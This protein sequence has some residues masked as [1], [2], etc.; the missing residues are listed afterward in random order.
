MNTCD[1]KEYLARREIPQL[2]ESL[3][4]GLVCYKPD[5]PI[6]YLEGC[7]QKVKE[8]GGSEKVKWDTFVSQEKRTLPP[9]NG[10]QSRR[11]FFRNVMPDNPNFPYRRYDRLPP[12]HQ[13]SIESDTDLSETAELIEEYDVF[14]PTRPRP[15]IILVLG[16]PGSGK[17]TQSLKIAERY[18]FEYISVGELL[19]KKIHNTSSNRKWSLIAKIITT[20]ELAPQETTITEIKQRLMQIPDEEGIVI[21][22]FPRD[23]AQALSF[24]DQICTP[25]L[26]VFLACSNQRLKER[27]L[28]RAEQQGRPDD[29][30]KATQRRLINFKQNAV[31]LV[32]Y[33]QEK[34]LIITFDAD[35]DEEEVFYDISMA[36]D[37]KLFPPKEAVAGPN[38]LDLSLIMDSGDVADTEFDFEDQAD[39]QSNFSGYENAGDFTEDLRKSNIIFVVGGPGSGKGTQCEQLAQKYGF[40]H[41]STGDLLR[42]ELTSSSE[43]SK[44]IKDIM[45]C[46]ELVPGDIVL[47]LLKEAMIARLG[48]TKGF[49]IDGYPWEVKQGEEFECKIGEPKL[50]LCLD[51]STETMSSRLLKRSQCTADAEAVMKRMATY[52]QATEPVIAYYEKKTQLCKINAEGTPEEVFLQVCT[53]VDCFLKKEEE[54][55]SLSAEVQ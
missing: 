13:F 20:G 36:V 43:R 3:L 19:R 1:A 24:E 25:D 42:R 28:K 44:L 9:L 34:G 30:L 37:N 46:G 6:E 40:T 38:E 27:L 39:D 49:L 18:G 2:F 51:C 17:G 8:L 21:D 32:K 5:D 45:E 29:N 33:F 16:G 48:D 31:P 54:A 23:V 50:V 22:G 12:I 53:S 52:Y 10:G 55:L 11:S 7:L 47:A 41:L 4:N 15:K 35:R 14:D 26:V